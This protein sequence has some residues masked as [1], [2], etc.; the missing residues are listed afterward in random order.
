MDVSSQQAKPRGEDS[1]WSLFVKL[2]WSVANVLGW[3][4]LQMIKWE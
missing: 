2:F 4:G 1:G 3:A